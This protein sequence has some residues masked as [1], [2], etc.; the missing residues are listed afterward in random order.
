MIRSAQLLASILCIALL[1]ACG[2]GGGSTSPS[3]PTPT[4]APVTVVL[5]QGS[6]PSF[7]PNTALFLD[8]ITTTRTGQLEVHA[9]WTSA[10][11]NVDVYI[12]Q[13]QCTFEQILEVRC[14]FIG[15]KQTGEKPERLQVAGVAPGVYQVILV[16]RGV[17]AESVSWQVLLVG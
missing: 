10:A 13:G 17:G 14:N 1:G 2:G 6:F 8:P 9:D 5:A 15:I 12:T 4:P 11:N 3:S 16:N 7:Q